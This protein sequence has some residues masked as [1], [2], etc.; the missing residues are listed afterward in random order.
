MRRWTPAVTRRSRSTSS[1]LLERH[2]ATR[3]RRG[4]DLHPRARARRSRRSSASASR[5]STA[6]S[7]RPA[8]RARRSRS[9]RCPSRSPTGSRSSGCGAD[10]RPQPR[11]RRAERRRVQRDQPRP[12]APARRCNPMINAGRDRLRRARRAARPTTRSTALLGRTRALRRAAARDRRGRLPLRDATPGTAT[13]RSPTCCAASASSTATPRRR[14]TSTSASARS[15]STAATSPSIAATLANG[16]VN[17][18]TGERAVARGRRA[19]RA[20]RDDD[21]RD[22]RRRRRVAVSV[23]LPAKSGVSGGVLRACSRAGSASPS[24]RR[25]STRAATACAASRVCRELSHDLALHLVR[26]GERPPRPYAPSTRSPSARRSA[27]AHRAQRA[28][29]ARG[30]GARRRLELQGELGFSAGEAL[31]RCVE[32]PGDAPSSS[33][34][35]CSRVLR[36]D[37]GGA[38]FS[39]SLAERIEGRGGRLALTPGGEPPAPRSAALPR[40]R[41]DRSPTSTWRSS[42]ARTS[43]SRARAS[44]P[45]PRTVPLADHE[46]LAGLTPPSSSASELELGSVVA[47]RR[48]AARAPGRGGLGASSSSRAARSAWCATAPRAQPAPH[49]ALGRQD[50]RRAG[51]RRS[52]RAHGRRA[53]RFRGRVPERSAT[54]PSTR[55]RQA[56]RRSTG[57]CSATC[58][59]SSPRP[60]TA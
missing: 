4:R 9:S 35:T 54:R 45:P 12:R 29:I 1:D 14:S 34:S 57:S 50:V 51:V 58:S 25:G 46:L 2:A 8:T 21:V 16:G 44:S 15:R 5:P 28:A 31:A 41:G 27:S 17:P 33:S 26:P 38:R 47:A 37:A 55:S 3:R 36:A 6:P 60:C 32:A 22:V 59:V 19:R 11:R 24:S 7:T 52:R 53:R 49:H 10:A 42:G 48:H 43:C 20:Q 30:R 13:A 39:P 56:I 18:I 40:G 23:G